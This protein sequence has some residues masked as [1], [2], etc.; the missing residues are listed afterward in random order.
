MFFKFPK[1]INQ[2]FIYHAGSWLNNAASGAWG[3]TGA[4]AGR[5]HVGSSHPSDG[6]GVRHGAAG[7]PSYRHRGDVQPPQLDSAGRPHITPT[8][9]ECGTAL[10]AFPPTGTLAAA[11][12]PLRS[13]ALLVTPL[14]SPPAPRHLLQARRPIPLQLQNMERSALLS[15]AV[16][17][18]R[19]WMT[20][21][22]PR[23]P[24]TN[25]RTT[26]AAT[27]TIL[28]RRLGCLSLRVTAI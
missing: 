17:D 13:A 23:H 14:A 8:G 10:L 6:H 26:A 18:K 27:E 24:R 19:M 4:P 21:Q 28:L 5:P 22:C 9:A 11:N 7:H 25:H 12:T 15:R 16:A 1:P 3:K 2:S 20:R